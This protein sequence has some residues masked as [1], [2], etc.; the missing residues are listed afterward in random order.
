[1]PLNKANSYGLIAGSI[2]HALLALK[3]LDPSFDD[4]AVMEIAKH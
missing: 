4:L 2:M 3:E 1:M